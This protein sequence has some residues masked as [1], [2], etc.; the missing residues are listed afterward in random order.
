MTTAEPDLYRIAAVLSRHGVN[1]VVIGGWAAE[2][3]GYDLGYL[4]QDIDV[5]PEREPTNLG[6]L[7][8]ALKA[9]GARVRGEAGESFAFD[10]DGST[11]ETAMVRNLTCEL[12]DFDLSFEPTAMG[13]YYDLVPAAVPARIVVD[14]QTTIVMC[15]DI[16]AIIASKTS[17]GRPKDQPAVIALKAQFEARRRQARHGPDAGLNL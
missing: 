17:A 3:Q 5:T 14:G 11:F 15:A 16:E 2:A 7:S 10:H 8:A 6:R 4:T 1:F 9:L 12:G 13:T